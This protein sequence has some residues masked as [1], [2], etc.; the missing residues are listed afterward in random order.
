MQLRHVVQVLSDVVAKEFGTE[1]FEIDL[2]YNEVFAINRPEKSMPLIDLIRVC[3][4]EGIH[5]SELA[6]FC[7]PFS[8]FL[9]TESGQGQVHS[10]YDYGAHAV[11]VSVDIETGEVEVRKS[12]AAHDIGQCI[13]RAAVEGKIQGGAQ[14]GKDML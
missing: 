7:A 1:P 11:E 3:G 2:G 14:N 4:T 13:N 10:D 6:M 9:D 12:I 8:D 5:R